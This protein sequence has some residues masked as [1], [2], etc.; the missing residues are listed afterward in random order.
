MRTL[1]STMTTSKPQ[2]LVPATGAKLSSFE[3]VLNDLR[4]EKIFYKLIE[5][6]R[7]EVPHSI[8]FA[9]YIQP[10]TSRTDQEYACFMVKSL[11]PKRRFFGQEL[12][13]IAAMPL[14]RWREAEKER[15]HYAGVPDPA[16]S[17]FAGLLRR[18]LTERKNLTELIG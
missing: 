10:L 15:W 12:M 18:H 17:V 13:T 6:V 5:L 8:Q 11:H 2:I 16:V 1:T 3:P 7:A 9:S 14:T 4:L